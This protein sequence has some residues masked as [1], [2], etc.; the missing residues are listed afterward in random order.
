M[1]VTTKDLEILAD[2]GD[3]VLHDF[4][5]FS[6]SHKTRTARCGVLKNRQPFM[7]YLP[8]Q[9]PDGA[10][11]CPYCADHKKAPRTRDRP[12][13]GKPGTVPNQPIREA[14]ERSEISLSNLA[15]RMGFVGTEGPEASRV[16]RMLGMTVNHRLNSG[17]AVKQRNIKEENAVKIIRALHL[18]PKDFDL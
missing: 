17:K 8:H 3:G 13:K 7:I 16:G 18:S 9:A 12:H 14:F 15:V 1:T 6:Q 5:W 10:T 2:Y 4:G 11:V